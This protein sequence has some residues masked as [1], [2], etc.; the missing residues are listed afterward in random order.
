MSG[1]TAWVKVSDHSGEKAD[2]NISLL[3][4]ALAMLP[5]I[6]HPRA[7]AWLISRALLRAACTLPSSY[8]TLKARLIS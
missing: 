2:V 7:Q 1:S 8:P 4:S 3:P 5:V 6:K